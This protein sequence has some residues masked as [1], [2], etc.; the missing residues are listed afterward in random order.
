[1]P[2]STPTS[3]AKSPSRRQFLKR[4]GVVAGSAMAGLAISRSA[5][6]AGSDTLKVGL[7]GCGGRGTGAAGNALNADANAKLVAM[8]DAFRDKVLASRASLAKDKP[9][10]V[11][12]DDDHCFVGFDG[13]RKVID[14]DVDVVL[15]ACASKFHPH[16]LKAAVDAGKHVFVE[17]PHSINAPDLKVVT[18]ACRSAKQKGLCVVSGLCWRYHRGVQ[19][20]VG[21]VLDGAIGEIVAIRE[22][23]ARSPYR[24]IERQKEWT[25]MEWQVRNWYHFRWL[26]GDDILQS[27]V[28]SLDKA[29]WIMREQPP[30]AAWGLGGRSGAVTAAD[31]DQFDHQAI[32]YEYPGG[33][34]LYG[35]SRD[36]A[37][38]YNETSDHILGTK[39]R[40][41][42]LNFKITGE[43][44]WRYEGP[45]CNMYDAEHVALFNA[46]R[47]GK[48]I[49][50]GNYMVPST[51]LGIIGRM[52]AYTGKRITWQQAR[53]SQ[54]LLGPAEVSFDIDPPIKPGAHG[55][56][57]VPVPGVTPFS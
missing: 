36:S 12:V 55:D 28:H 48:P 1:M 2:Q 37:G 43:T 40:C 51:M 10:Q 39:G 23:Y 4:S 20:T 49:N 52:A 30:V 42:L 45:D 24:M 50:N 14:S 47:A 31:G 46:I 44:N 54:D 56:Y 22:T 35:F 15:I 21:R 33:V 7:I 29:A 3:A 27:L 5:H 53:D 34:E 26:S 16:Y 11:T 19:E 18:E 13:Y 9:A 8:A 57:S 32:V 17:K 38:C 25:E 6:A 41:D